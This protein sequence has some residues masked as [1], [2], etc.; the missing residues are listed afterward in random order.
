MRSPQQQLLDYKQFKAARTI[1]RYYRGWRVRQSMKRM[2]HASTVMQRTWLRFI[3][4]RHLISIG[5]ELVQESIL[6]MLNKAAIKIQALFR[7]WWVRKHINNMFYLKEIQLNC[8]EE[9]LAG[10]AHSLHNMM[11]TQQLPGYMSLCKNPHVQRVEDLMETMSYR[12]YNRYVGTRF[13][14]D[15]ATL[16]IHRREFRDSKFWNWVPYAGFNHTGECHQPPPEKQPKTYT[17][18]EYD[19][20]QIFTS[21]GR[22]T[23]I[24]K[25]KLRAKEDKI[26]RK[27][28]A[29]CD[30]ERRFCK[31]LVTRMTA[32]PMCNACKVKVTDTLLGPN[33]GEFLDNV[34]ASLEAI[35]QLGNCNCQRDTIPKGYIQPCE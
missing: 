25:K 20:V 9:L 30:N 5:E 17:V 18:R 21:V 14:S 33:L 22:M 8:I 6:K 4:K 32:W 13:V 7:G 12:F 16:E 2:Q 3:G 15:R 19:V 31:D 23:E 35:H 1:Q 29:L 27:S 26:R 11:R 10:Y 24:K 28:H 34:K